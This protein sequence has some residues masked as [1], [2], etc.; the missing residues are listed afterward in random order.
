MIC[1]SEQQAHEAYAVYQ[2]SVPPKERS[3]TFL[4]WARDQK[5]MFSDIA[6]EEQALLNKK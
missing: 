3:S 6:P 4:E 2:G 5:I 1:M